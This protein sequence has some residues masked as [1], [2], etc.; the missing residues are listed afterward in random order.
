MGLNLKK[1][2]WKHCYIQ[3]SKESLIW[4]E[5]LSCI[6]YNHQIY[7][8]IFR[9]LNTRK[10]V[11]L[12]VGKRQKFLLSLKANSNLKENDFKYIQFLIVENL[13]SRHI[14]H[15]VAMP[16]R[17]KSLSEIFWSVVEQGQYF[18]ILGHNDL[19]ICASSIITCFQI[20]S[21]I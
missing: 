21:L 2:L 15:T 12:Y 4:N 5:L 20:L 3:R 14:V 16:N 17:S 19:R 11:V 8:R 10:T 1:N 7:C 13:Q 9:V 6:R 18:K